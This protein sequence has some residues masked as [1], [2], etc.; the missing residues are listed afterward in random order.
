MAKTIFPSSYECNCGHESH[1]FEGTIWDMQKMSRNNKKEVV[2]ADDNDHKIIF[3]GGVA[4]AVVCPKL[5][6]CSLD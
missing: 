5:G 4:V 2:L 1:F 6:E 3:K